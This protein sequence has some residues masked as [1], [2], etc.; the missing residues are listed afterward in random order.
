M[1]ET[2]DLEIYVLTAPLGRVA[3]DGR[4]VQVRG[5]GGPSLDRVPMGAFK[6][7]MTRFMDAVHSMV[8]E[9]KTR[10]D[11]FE[12]H[13]IEIAASIG[14]DGKVAFLGSGVGVDSSASFKVK[15][16]RPK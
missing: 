2:D 12:I 14:A 5:G 10:S 3:P 1:P 7:G 9:I 8:G 16:T 13:E 15:L 4:P 11:G 6:S